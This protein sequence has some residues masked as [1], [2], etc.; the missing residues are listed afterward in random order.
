MDVRETHAETL[1]TTQRVVD[2]VHPEHLGKSTPCA[3]WNVGELIAHLVG[4]NEVFAAAVRGEDP[5][6][7]S[8]EDL[9]G[10]D[11]AG[12]YRRSVEEAVAAWGQPDVL[13][14]TLH[15]PFGHMPAAFAIGIHFIDNL[16]H[17]WDLATATGQDHLLNSESAGLA[18]QMCQQN[19]AAMPAEQVRGP[20][21]PFG[22]IVDWPD[23]APVH[24]RLVAFL[25]RH[26]HGGR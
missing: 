16:V 17:R 4:V 23:E 20:G 13:E 24:E 15:L 9:L 2:G 19:F 10:D 7:A 8:E 1:R 14:Q 18:L 3:E 6:S 21:K 12:A 25:G 5:R 11:P 26:P 22:D